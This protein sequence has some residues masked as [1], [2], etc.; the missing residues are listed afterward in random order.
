MSNIAVLVENVSK[1]Y[2][3]GSRKKAHDSLAVALFD[4]IKR[5]SRNLKRL[6]E[7]S[8]FDGS[9]NDSE[10]TIWA[11]KGVSLDV[12]QGEVVGIIGRNGS[13]KSTL[14]KIISRITEPTKG[15]GE[16]IGRI[17][18]L[19]EVGTGFHPELTGRENIYLNGAILGMKKVEIDHK[20][21]EIVDFSGVEKFIDTPVKRYS[22][23]MRVRL[24]FAVAAHVEPEILLIDEVLAV[25]DAAFQKRCL[26]KMEE[27]ASEGRT[28]IF[29]SHNMTAVQSLCERVI[30]LDDGRVVEEGRPDS[31]VS[32]YLQASF[33]TLTERL[34]DDITI[35]PGNDR[36]RLHL[37]RIRP[38]KG[39]PLDRISIRTPLVMEFEYWNLEP[40]AHLNLSVCLYNET[41]VMVFNT[42]PVHEPMWQGRPFPVGLFRSQC[43]IPGDLLNDGMHRVQLLVVKDQG[44]VV[45]R[46]RSV[47]VFDVAD[48]SQMRG[49]WHGKWRGA[50]RPNLKWETEHLK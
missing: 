43:R 42:A 7:L 47:L 14:L 33:E 2:R 6:R 40:A 19:L 46:D 44:V 38:E 10:N 21:D 39:S 5:P 15:R 22:S 32:K 16:T 37:A 28:I 48:D 45:F 34:W 4:F 1:R 29:V 30:W 31:V 23:G 9:S 17:G 35:A 26:G 11:L 24:A 3:I 41:G 18:S 36:V 12:K 13:G 50:V 27:V 25:G 20:F 49:E 8:T